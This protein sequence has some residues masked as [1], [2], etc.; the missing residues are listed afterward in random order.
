METPYS[1]EFYEALQEGSRRSAREIIPLVLE[2]TQ[3]RSVVDV[4]CGSGAWLSVFKE[5][6]ISKC[7]GID[8]DY[9]QKEVLQIPPEEFL[10]HD[11]KSPLKI[12]KTFDLVLSLEVAEHLDSK[13]ADAFVNSLVRLGPII[14]FSAAIPYQ[15]GTDHLNEQW[16]DYWVS[17]FKDRGY[18][19]IDYLRKKL[20]NNIK[21]EPWYAQNI[22]FFIKQDCLGKYPL[23]AKEIENTNLS[24]I[25]IVHPEIYLKNFIEIASQ[26]KYYNLPEKPSQGG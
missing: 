10:A 24:Q 19:V 2:L 17:R 13:Y 6:G 5:L 16:P 12:S 23:L 11:L 3:P 18:W 25:A 7:L 9:V 20:W 4:G 26:N 22:L 14:L 1:K 15:G 8:G 21:V